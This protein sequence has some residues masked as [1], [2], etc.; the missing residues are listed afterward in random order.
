MSN[1]IEP[2]DK[3]VKGESEKIKQVNI[4]MPLSMYDDFMK[5]AKQLG[6]TTFSSYV[7]FKL[8]DSG[9]SYNICNG[10]K[11]NKNDNLSCEKTD[12]SSCEK[13]DN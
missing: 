11:S 12:N 2:K 7:R 13:N 10:C 3:K 1:T 5:D 6:F 8:F 4:S 9:T